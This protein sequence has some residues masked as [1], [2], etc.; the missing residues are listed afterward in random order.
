ML[1]PK[2]GSNILLDFKNCDFFVKMTKIPIFDFEALAQI[3]KDI[4]Q[5]MKDFISYLHYFI[6]IQGICYNMSHMVFTRYDPRL[7][8]TWS[9]FIFSSDYKRNLFFPKKLQ[10]SNMIKFILEKKPTKA[11]KNFMS[12]RPNSS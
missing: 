4:V 9:E 1:I 3:M 11:I 5:K 12:K 8:L 6:H 2:M 7:L 10:K